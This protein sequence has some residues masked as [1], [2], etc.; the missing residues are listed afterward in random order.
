MSYRAAYYK[1]NKAK[2]DAQN[3]AWYAAHPG[4]R[5]IVARRAA[6]KARYGLTLAEFASILAKQKNRCGLCGRKTPTGKRG[7]HVDHK[8]KK[9]RGILC[10]K[11]NVGLG[12]FDDSPRLLQKAIAYLKACTCR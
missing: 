6:L 1:Q 3:K 8:H 4:V 5:K 2:I 9:V 10:S 7:W 11:C 12:A